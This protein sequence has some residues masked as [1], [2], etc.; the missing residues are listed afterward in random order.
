MKK[1]IIV[2]IVAIILSCAVIGLNVDFHS[3]QKGDLNISH[4]YLAESSRAISR[5]LGK[6]KESLELAQTNMV[7]IEYPNDVVVRFFEDHAV[8]IA[9]KEL[10]RDSELLVKVGDSKES[11][12]DA[13][14]KKPISTTDTAS[15]FD[16]SEEIELG[17]LFEENSVE[18]LL[19]RDKSILGSTS[20]K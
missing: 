19:L 1:N 11:I 10:Y 2:V 7:E 9:G 8:L 13:L 17:V 20:H 18:V 12:S 16:L 6:A 14:A 3:T 5:K 15:Y 4:T